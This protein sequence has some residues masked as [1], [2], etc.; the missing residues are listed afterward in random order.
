[1]DTAGKW[2]ASLFVNII[3]CMSVEG[4]ESAVAYRVWLRGCAREQL[5]WAR[6]RPSACPSYQPDPMQSKGQ[7]RIRRI[8]V[9]CYK[10]KGVHETV[11]VIVVG[12][13]HNAHIH[14]HSLSHTY[15]CTHTQTHTHT[16]MHTHAHTHTHQNI[17]NTLLYEQ[18]VPY[19][20][21]C[22]PLGNVIS[23]VM[24]AG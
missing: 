18:P 11:I 23:A 9:R 15:L 24:M 17:S 20:A 10:L 3:M 7:N 8:L 12:L 19:I 22:G 5:W 13:H 21:P 1:M 4:G 14:A 2:T 16:H 6:I